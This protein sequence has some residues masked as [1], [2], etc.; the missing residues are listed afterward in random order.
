MTA[1]MEELMLA[2]L[3]AHNGEWKRGACDVCRSPLDFDAAK[4]WVTGTGAKG[5]ADLTPD[6][7]DEHARELSLVW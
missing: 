6:L 1:R 3:A 4:K 5:F 7:C 2:Y